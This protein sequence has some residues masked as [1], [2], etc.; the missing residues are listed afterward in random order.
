[1]WRGL[2]RLDLTK[3]PAPLLR[4]TGIALTGI[5]FAAIGAPTRLG[6]WLWA[7]I[8]GGFLLL[9]DITGFAVGGVRVELRKIQEELAALRNEVN[10]RASQVTNVTISQEIVRNAIGASFVAVRAEREHAEPYVPVRSPEGEGSI[11]G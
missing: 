8:I 9:P 4:W 2:A 1:M 3:P 10:V 7:A 11:S 6:D 5:I